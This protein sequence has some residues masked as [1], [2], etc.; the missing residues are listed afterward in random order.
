MSE[1]LSKTAIVDLIA[2]KSGSPKTEAKQCLETVLGVIAEQ[3]LAGNE[4]VTQELGTFKLAARPARTGRNPSTGEPL[5]IKAS[6]TVKLSVSK[7]LK[8][9]LNK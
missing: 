2:T 6:K 8:D 7:S 5:E 4:V 3:L 1:R 9:A